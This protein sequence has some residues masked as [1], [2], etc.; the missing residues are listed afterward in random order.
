MFFIESAGISPFA[1]M[2]SQARISISNHF[3]YRFSGLQI[4]SIFARE[5]RCINFPLLSRYIS[6]G[7]D[8][9]PLPIDALKKPPEQAVI[10][11]VFGLESRYL[12]QDP[13]LE[14]DS[15]CPVKTPFRPEPESKEIDKFVPQPY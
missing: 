10:Y 9:H 6:T 7:S 1:A 15:P 8:G 4:A 14:R 11:Y 2:A 12:R 3:R 5:Y 13:G